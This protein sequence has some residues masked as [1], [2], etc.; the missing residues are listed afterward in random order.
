MEYKTD[1]IVFGKVIGSVIYRMFIVN[2]MCQQRVHSR[3]CI[4]FSENEKGMYKKSFRDWY[5]AL[6]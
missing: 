4:V 2:D 5:R 6:Q 3:R 1:I